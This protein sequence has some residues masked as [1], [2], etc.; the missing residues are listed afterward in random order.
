MIEGKGPHWH[1][2]IIKVF[3]K[4]FSMNSRRV[5]SQTCSP[6]VKVEQIDFWNKE[7]F[8]SNYIRSRNIDVFSEVRGKICHCE[9]KLAK[10]MWL[11][12]LTFA[13]YLG[14]FKI[15]IDTYNIYEYIYPQKGE[16]TSWYSD[17]VQYLKLL[18][19]ICNVHNI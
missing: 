15:S 16:N 12:S 2:T 18:M 6:D 9:N 10:L 17:Q 11:P 13:K 8:P 14:I 1:Q 5:Q 19:K 4:E 3:A 7:I